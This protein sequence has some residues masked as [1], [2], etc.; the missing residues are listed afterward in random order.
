MSHTNWA[1]QSRKEL[2]REIEERGQKLNRAKLRL[3]EIHR[4]K[5]HR[6]SEDAF[7]RSPDE[8]A[9]DDR[10]EGLR[11]PED[12]L[13]LALDVAQMA[14]CEWDILRDRITGTPGYELLWGRDSGSF[15]GSFAEFL[16]C[17]HPDDRGAITETLEK[18]H[19]GCGN[20][21]L[22]FRVMWPDRSTHW[23]ESQGKFFYSDRQEVI[24]AVGTWSILTNG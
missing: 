14:I 3:Q 2:I 5:S 6:R 22:K 4:P 8:G 20:Y 17:I 23:I 15:N 18:A 16:A 10:P 9:S 13:R 24:R 21:H 7:P 12:W 11:N 1:N 19:Q